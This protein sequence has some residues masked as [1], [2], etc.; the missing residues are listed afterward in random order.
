MTESPLFTS[1]RDHGEFKAEL[2]EIRERLDQLSVDLATLST[3]VQ[4]L[5][6]EIRRSTSN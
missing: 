3:Q 1:D 5:A 6:A 2:R 4:D